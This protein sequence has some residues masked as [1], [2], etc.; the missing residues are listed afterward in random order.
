[1]V[2]GVIVKKKIK[3]EIIGI[4]FLIMATY[5]GTFVTIPEVSA[6]DPEYQ[7]AEGSYLFHTKN[8][9]KKGIC[10]SFIFIL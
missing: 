6:E 2:W 8:F 4:V 10:F 9:N 1:M 3:V 5:F 7:E